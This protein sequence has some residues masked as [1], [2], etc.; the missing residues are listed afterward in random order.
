MSQILEIDELQELYDS[1][2]EDFAFVDYEPALE[3]ELGHVA[4]L[5]A[6][7]FAAAT[8]PA[9]EAWPPNAPRTIRA[10]GHSRILVGKTRRLINS[11]TGKQAAGDSLRDVSEQS[12]GAQL[13]FG[14]LVEYSGFNDRARGN[15]PARPHV[16]LNDKYL[17]QA[18]NRLVDFTLADM[19]KGKI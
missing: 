4:E 11:L 1:I 10:K 15:A 19:A 14:T 7:F 18:T 8:D 2:A 17:D 13:L 5:H 3:E 16:G 6:G 9:G 12:D